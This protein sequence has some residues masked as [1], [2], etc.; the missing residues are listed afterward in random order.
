MKKILSLLFPVGLCAAL[1]LSGCGSKEPDAVESTI[2]T[3]TTESSVDAP[4][5][6]PAPQTGAS[7]FANVKKTNSTTGNIIGEYTSYEQTNGVPDATI[8]LYDD[9]SCVFEYMGLSL[10][11]FLD[12]YNYYYCVGTEPATGCY[13]RATFSFY[14]EYCEGNSFYIDELYH[15][16]PTITYGV[17]GLYAPILLKGEYGDIGCIYASNDYYMVCSYSG[18]D[19]H[20]DEYSYTEVYVG[21]T[22]GEDY[23][24]MR[25]DLTAIPE[26]SISISENAVYTSLEPAK[27]TFEGISDNGIFVYTYSCDNPYIEDYNSYN[28]YGYGH[29]DEYGLGEGYGG[30]DYDGG[31]SGYYD[32]GGDW[33]DEGSGD[34]SDEEYEAR[35]AKAKGSYRSKP[36]FKL[37]STVVSIALKVRFLLHDIAL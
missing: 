19:S 28:D 6:V 12:E 18:G 32:Y 8:T 14:P 25:K 13:T 20:A 17:K 10:S 29:G 36:R 9:N 26:L 33:Y 24:R 23:G 34:I 22:Y 4:A 7:A 1:L 35:L 2:P 37:S 27:L 5:N 21:K 15:P 31:D 16:Y 11:G 30:D 3:P